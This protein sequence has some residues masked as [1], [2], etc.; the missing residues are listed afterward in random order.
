[1]NKNTLSQLRFIYPFRKYQNQILLQVEQN[2][3][4]KSLHQDSKKIHIVSP[5]G[6]GKTI[7]G[8]ELI[9]RLGQPAVVFCPTT[10][11]ALQW[12]EKVK[13]FIPPELKMKISEV[14]TTDADILKDINCFTYQ[15][16]SSPSENLDFIEK[17]ALFSWKDTLVSQS[18]SENEEEAAKRIQQLKKNNPSA[19]QSELKKYYKKNKDQFL[20][21]PLFDGTQLLHK[22]AQNLIQR[23]VDHGVKT[24]ILDE[25]HHL[26]D[27]WALVIKEL[28]KRIPDI[29]VIG[30]TATPPI[31]ADDDELQNYLSIMG[32]IDFE[33]PTPAVVKEGNLAPYQDLV[34]L[35]EPTPLEYTFITTLQ[36]R[37]DLLVQEIGKRKSFSEWILQR[38]L[39]RKMSADG[40][41][42]EWSAFFHTHVNLAIAG[43]KYLQQILKINLPREVVVIEEMT[44][45]IN[46]QD[47]VYL[48]A[49]YSLNYLK[50]SEDQSDHT[51]LRDIRNIL[52]SFGFVLSE[53]GIR[54]YRSP[55][56]SILAFSKAKALSTVRL[57]KHEMQHMKENLRAVVITD[58]EKLS[59]VAKELTTILDPKAGG[60]VGVFKDIVSDPATTQLEPILVTGT[61]VLVDK[62]ELQRILK[63]MNEWK[64]NSDLQFTLEIEKTEYDR[65][66][67]I[68]GKGKDWRSNTYVRMI[69]HLFELGITKCIVGTR[70]L[71]GEGWD[72]LSLNTLIDLTTATTSTTVNQIRGR[73]IRLNPSWPRKLS[74]NWDIV[75][76]A[77]KFQRGKQDFDRFERKHEKIYGLDAKGRVIKGILH[78]DSNLMQAFSIKMFQKINISL[79]NG[80]ML[81]KS[82][83][84]NEAYDLWRIGEPYSD[85]EYSAT[86]LQ[87]RD[88]KFQTVYSL[89]DSLIA[90]FNRIVIQTGVV[91]G[92]Y[93]S[94]LGNGWYSLLQYPRVPF[95]AASILVVIITITIFV[96]IKKYIRKA[97]IEVPVDSHLLDIGKALLES[98]RNNNLINS[99]HS[100]DD[101]RVVEDNSKF[102]DVYLDYATKED[103][104]LFSRCFNQILTPV[105]DQR[106]L[107]SRSV[108]NINIGF[109]SPFWWIFRKIFRLIRQEK[110]AYHP[111]PDLLSLNKKRASSFAKSWN[112]YVGGSE[113]IYTR[114]Q[115]GIKT[116][117]RLRKFNRHQIQRVSVEM[118]K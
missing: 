84:R 60:A 52:K 37:F 11:I 99:R 28:I 26:L 29:H 72:S 89:R 103:A 63:A 19:Y 5:P 87:S 13:L 78:V 116:L 58:F 93:F 6:S 25:S 3:A 22:N 118:W 1:M 55:T 77:P 54:E 8:L 69:T 18:I 42:Q 67:K 45:E 36:E 27:Y 66:V 15:L 49:D 75:C 53:N 106:Y 73:S 70:G 47:W 112:K 41:K 95:I 104:F 90:I 16:I 94:F 50:L 24:L 43:V 102:Y 108:D 35:C 105:S 51:E 71:L 98:L 109:Y 12:K 4:Q 40:K 110:V 96:D 7:V 20:R 86:K 83:R 21:D 117:L 114:S 30:L 76:I 64:Q 59:A 56:D 115:T 80:R 88:F 14:A 23:L 101:V 10:T 32:E 82:A 31:S 46:L 113:L 44:A 62:D 79:I 68:V 57:L 100:L 39:T 81:A 107:V 61:T 34:Y 65:I 91:V 111:V 92:Y 2:S 74:N 33:I 48:L 9:R 38:L 85:F 97:F 17:A